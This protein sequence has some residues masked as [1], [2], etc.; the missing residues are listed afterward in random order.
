MNF[1]DLDDDDNVVL[2][3]P[4]Q[5]SANPQVCLIPYTNC[6]N[7][8][9]DNL[10]LPSSQLNDVLSEIKDTFLYKDSIYLMRLANIMVNIKYIESTLT[11]LLPTEGEGDVSLISYLQSLNKGIIEALGNIPRDP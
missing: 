2:T 5:F 1:D 11:S 8:D 9:G 6:A 3:F 10:I 4:G 7:P